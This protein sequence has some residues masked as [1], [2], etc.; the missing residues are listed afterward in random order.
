VEIQDLISGNRYDGK[1]DFAVVLQP[2]LQTSFIPTIGVG[3]VDTSFFSVDCFHIS[4][5]AHA[6]M[7]IA[8]WNNMLEPLGRKQAFNNF[9]Y[10]RSKIHCPT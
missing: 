1:D 8:L 2:F 5:R 6:E 7:A 9:T 10:D 4:E 3:E